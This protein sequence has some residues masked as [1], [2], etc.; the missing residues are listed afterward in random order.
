MTGYTVFVSSDVSSIKVIFKLYD[1][2]GVEISE[3]GEE[4]FAKITV[5]DSSDS[6]S[7]MYN[8]GYGDG[9]AVNY[10]SSDIKADSSNEFMV[11]F[12]SPDTGWD[13][14]DC[15]TFQWMDGN[16]KEILIEEAGFFTSKI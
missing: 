13:N 15:F 4:D 9:Y 14:A 16:I 11:I 10:L 1:A 7:A 12:E 6:G 5:N 3:I 2:D 8:W